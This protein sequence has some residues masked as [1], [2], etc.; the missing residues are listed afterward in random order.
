MGFWGGLFRVSAGVAF[1]KLG[2]V[3]VADFYNHR[4]QIF[5]SAGTFLGQFG[6]EGKD[7]AQFDGPTALAISGEGTVYVGD[8]HNHRIHRFLIN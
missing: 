1:D 3:F 5:D 4:I 8:F 2:R 7:P 6:E